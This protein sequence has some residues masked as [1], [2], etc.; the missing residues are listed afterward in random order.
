MKV[1]GLTGNIASGKTE[2][3]KIF[4]ELGAN[5]ID[6]DHIA[7][8]VVKPGEVAWKDICDEFG[9]GFSILIEL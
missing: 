6:A 7:R 3:A 1:V 5:V 9:G 4:K 2:V 8:E